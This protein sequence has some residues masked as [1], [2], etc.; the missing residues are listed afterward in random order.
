MKGIYYDSEFTVHQSYQKGKNKKWHGIYYKKNDGCISKVVVF[1]S[2]LTENCTDDSDIDLCFFTN[3]TCKNPVYADIYG[4]MEIVMDD[5]CDILSYRK[6]DDHGGL[7]AEI[8]KNGVVIYE[9][10]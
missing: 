8:D 7:K 2:S 1:G 5:L 9:Y 4:K 3:A 10:K 6:L